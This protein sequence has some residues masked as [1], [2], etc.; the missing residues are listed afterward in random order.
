MVFLNLC[1]IFSRYSSYKEIFET[2]LCGILKDPDFYPE[3]RD[4]ETL[5]KWFETHVCATV[6]DLG[7]EP[8]EIEEF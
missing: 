4:Y 2:E 6:F 8:I 3:K 1:V 7:D 5:N